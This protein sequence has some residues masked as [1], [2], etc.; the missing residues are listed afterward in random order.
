MV[1]L[2]IGAS[3]GQHVIAVAV[4]LVGVPVKRLEVRLA[5]VGAL[6]RTHAP[7]ALPFGRMARAGQQTLH[8]H[9]EQAL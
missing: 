3:F 8:Q 4:E 7:G 9:H 1:G 5:P 6:A 2:A